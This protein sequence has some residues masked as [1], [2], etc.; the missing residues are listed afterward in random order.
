M[1]KNITFER[2]RF[3]R[4]NQSDGESI[5]QYIVALYTLVE[6]CQHGDFKEEMIRDRLVVGIKDEALSAKLQMNPNL[7]LEEISTSARG[8]SRAT[9]ATKSRREQGQSN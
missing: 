1:R 7:T 8:S 2:A 4:R 3:N 6:D 5:E 9:T